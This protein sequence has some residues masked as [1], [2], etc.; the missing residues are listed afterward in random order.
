MAVGRP[1][2]VERVDEVEDRARRSRRPARGPAP[3]ARRG[4]RARPGAG[5]SRPGRVRRPGRRR[6]AAPGGGRARRPS[7]RPG[8]PRRTRVSTSWVETTIVVPD[9]FSS[10][11]SSITTRAEAGSSALVGS[12]KTST[13]GRMA[14]TP[15][16]ATAFFSPPERRCGGRPSKP[17][18]PTSA[19]APVTARRTSSPESP[20]LSGPKATSWY[21]VGAKSWASEFWRTSP[22]RRRRSR[23]CRRSYRN[24]SPWRRISPAVGLRRPFAISRRVDLP[25]P[26]GPTSATLAPS[27]IS[28][29]TSR[30]ASWPFGYVY[31]TPTASSAG[32]TATLR[33]ARAGPRRAE[34]RGRRRP[35]GRGW[36]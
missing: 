12:S 2:R 31:R 7:A 17:R 34:G 10:S 29:E 28:I 36:L 4:P 30:R 9:A 24:G 27:S 26:F 19:S 15:A 20:R 35:R 5:A 25:A 6:R 32:V 33:P 11:R 14:S 3:R 21:T 22:T 1:G 18:R 8:R 16:I 23:R 13:S